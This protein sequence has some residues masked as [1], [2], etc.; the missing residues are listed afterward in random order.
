MKR[1][2]FYGFILFPGGYYKTDIC[3][4]SLNDILGW[5]LAQRSKA[6][7]NASATDENMVE[8]STSRRFQLQYPLIALIACIVLYLVLAVL[9]ARTKAPWCDEGWFGN[10]AYNLAFHGNL[11]SN[12]LEPSGHFLN[13]YLRG[14]QERTYVVPP[15][16]LVA[17]A[18]WFRIMGFS[19]FTMR[20]Y[21]ILWGVVILVVFFYVLCRLIPDHRVAN[22]AALLTAMD[23]VFVW[24]SADGRMEAAACGLA[25]GSIAAYLRYRERNYSVAVLASQTLGA[26]AVFTHPNALIVLL[27]VFVIALSQDRSRMRPAHLAIAISPYIIFGILWLVYILRAPSDFVSQFLANAAGQDN[28]RWRIIV[29]PWL[30]LYAEL[31]RHVTLYSASGLWSAKMSPALLFILP[32]YAAAMV[33]FY[34][35]HKQMGTPARNF[36]ICVT[37]ILLGMTFLNGFKAHCYMLY[38]MP[39]YNAVL[40]AWTI[41][42]WDRRRDWPGAAVCISCVFAMLQLGTIFQHISADEYHRDY[43]PTIR[44]IQN[45][46]SA[47]K[48][49]M[50]T[51]ALGFGTGFS[52]F[53]DD[54]RLGLYSRL[55]PDVIILDRSYREFALRFRKREPVVFLHILATL[56]SDYHL[57][58]RHGSYWVFE[59]RTTH[60]V[61]Q[62][63][64][65]D[66]DS[67]VPKGNRELADITFELLLGIPAQSSN[68]SPR[69]L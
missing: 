34:R 32:L 53:R 66:I 18:G 9:V 52:G 39:F 30:A 51:A 24:G 59:R 25:I 65:I 44:L 40:A 41:S 31:F 11:G 2:N 49:V 43:Q 45:R 19:I 6:Q 47:G 50:G 13:Q 12:V 7:P 57:T 28:S 33:W 62:A 60:L 38:A 8:E 55:K 48:T 29:R 46:Q 21:S 68:N 10:P 3:F 64:W 22:L 5:N 69:N 35:N 58:E 61:K 42:L 17:L 14:I 4:K 67:I 16:H 37:I 56:S 27:P 1:G 23:F 54:W 20:M 26:A 36:V 63:P 15:T